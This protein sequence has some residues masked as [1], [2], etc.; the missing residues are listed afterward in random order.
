M[1]MNEIKQFK[2]TILFTILIAISFYFLLLNL[3]F[4]L[5]TISYLFSV[6]YPFL[7]GAA[8][9]FILNI[10]MK[11]FEKKLKMKRILAFLLT[12]ICFVA[13]A[14]LVLFLVIPEL[15]HTIN[16]LIVQIPKAFYSI[17][18]MVE[19]YEEQLPA[20]VEVTESLNINWSKLS[21]EI[22]AFIQSVG[23]GVLNSTFS[24][25]SGITSAVITFFVGFTFSI[26]VLFQKEKLAIQMKKILYAFC[27]LAISDRI[28]EITTLTRQTFEHFLSGQCVEAIIL[29]SLFFLTMSIFRLPYA[30]LVGVAIA[31]TALIPVFGAFIGLL[32]GTFLIVMVN[33]MQALG[34]VILF[35]VLQQLEGN[36][37]YPYVVGGSVGLPS[38]W[39]LAAVTIGGKLF[40]IIGMF[41]FIPICSVFYILFREHVLQRIKQKEIP[42]VKWEADES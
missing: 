36:L 12:L 10:P 28:L 38:I 17:Q 15:I 19:Q 35:L 32:I 2:K 31:V 13:V 18:E 20:F 11:T 42:E 5:G 14:F 25:V 34:F 30:L 40:G 24:I 4:V 9:A 8:I 21:E 1:L 22:V 41:L 16:V 6:I 29:G 26:Y 33:P 3:S 7:F 27:P 39:V 23:S 37:I